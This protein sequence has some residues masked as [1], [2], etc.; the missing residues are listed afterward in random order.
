MK[1]T[2]SRLADFPSP[3]FEI[4]HQGQVE[5]FF[6]NDRWDQITDF[7]GVEWK[8]LKFCQERPNPKL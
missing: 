6:G 8:G 7:L 4:K 3:W 5:H 1:P 2:E